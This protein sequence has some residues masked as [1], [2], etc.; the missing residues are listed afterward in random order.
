MDSTNQPL[1]DLREIRNMME[2]STRFISLSGL[3]GI[4]AGLIALAGAAIAFFLLSYDQRYFEPG[5]Y[6]SP[7]SDHYNGFIPAL[8]MDA[9]IVLISALLFSF[10]FTYKRARKKGLPLWDNTTRRMLIA[11]SLPLVAGGVFCLVLIFHHIIYLIAPATLI[12]YG[13]ALISASYFSLS[14]L[15]FLGISELLLG[16][17]ASVFVGY[18]LI[19]W[20]AGFGVLHIIYGFRMYL[21]YER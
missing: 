7:G 14:E 9:A 10:Y 8:I 3:S 12:F 5:N 1:E 16:L 17:I 21:K 4:S 18:G 19:F 13:L 2:R 11:L 15:K 20:A 6:F